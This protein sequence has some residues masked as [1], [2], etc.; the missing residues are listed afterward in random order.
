MGAVWFIGVVG[1]VLA[2]IFYA[3]YASDRLFWREP[4][5]YERKG[6]KVFD[7]DLILPYLFF[8]IPL[9]LF[10]MVIVPLYGVFLLGKKL[11][12][13]NGN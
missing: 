5:S 1:I 7:A 3:G 10:W 2:R 11:G 8:T 12:Q 4:K 6:A 9:A 13:R